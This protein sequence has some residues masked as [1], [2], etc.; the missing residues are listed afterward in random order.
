MCHLMGGACATLCRVMVDADH[1]TWPAE[2]TMRSCRFCRRGINLWIGTQFAA[3]DVCRG[4]H[5][6]T[7]RMERIGVSP[8]MRGV[9]AITHHPTCARLRLLRHGDHRHDASLHRS[10]QT[11]PDRYHQ[12]EILGKVTHTYAI[13]TTQKYV[14]WACRYG[15]FLYR[16]R[17]GGFP[18]CRIL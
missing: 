1:V 12:S 14:L 2:D 5:G 8:S 11:L 16:H 15:I 18:N 7:V 10:R 4:M 9:Q 3:P 6:E 13:L 17:R